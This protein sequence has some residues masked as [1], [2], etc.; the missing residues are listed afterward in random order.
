LSRWAHALNPQPA[1][2]LQTRAQELIEQCVHSRGPCEHPLSAIAALRAMQ[3]VQAHKAR[4]ED[5]LA[6]APLEV[7]AE[8]WRNAAA[9]APSFEQPWSTQIPMSGSPN[10]RTRLVAESA[11]WKQGLP[12]SCVS[13]VVQLARGEWQPEYARAVWSHP[14]AALAE[15]ERLLVASGGAPPS[16]NDPGLGSQSEIARALLES[17]GAL[18]GVNYE[19]VEPGSWAMRVLVPLLRL[20]FVVPLRIRHESGSAHALL[21]LD[22]SESDEGALVRVADPATGTA[23]W[24]E[25]E[26]LFTGPLSALGYPHSR[27]WDLAVPDLAR[28]DLPA[29]DGVLARCAFPAHVSGI[30]LGPARSLAV[31]VTID[32]PS[33][34]AHEREHEHE[35]EHE[36]ERACSAEYARGLVIFRE[37]AQ[38][39]AVH[40]GIWQLYERLGGV[41]AAVGLPLSGMVTERD[42]EVHQAF[43]HG[44]IHWTAKRGAWLEPNEGEG[45]AR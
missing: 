41:Q 45:G 18:S 37:G 20:G 1:A 9:H 42:G 6:T 38:P 7:I 39:V 40:D 35:H 8:R 30:D 21:V 29:L 33:R 16:P 11:G 22:A 28:S 12:R 19:T 17:V 10:G 25:A 43:E 2:E 27:L 14:D 4:A 24:V 5:L 3:A 26:S 23:S 44:Q 31:P 13:A 32:R 15:Q 36:H 34:R